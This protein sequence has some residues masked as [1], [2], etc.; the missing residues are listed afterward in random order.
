[1]DQLILPDPG[2]PDY[3]ARCATPTVLQPRGGRQRPTCPACGWVY[4][5]RPALGAAVAVE[6]DGGLVLVQRRF[7]PYAGWWMLTAGLV[8]YGEFAEYTEAREAEVVT[9]LEVCLYALL[10]V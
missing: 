2:R 9:G 1:M 4:Y 8:E 5:A 6:R 10:V 7:E 3:C